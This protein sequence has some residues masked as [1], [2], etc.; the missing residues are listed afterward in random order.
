[1]RACAETE[2]RRRIQEA[3]NRQ[4]GIEPK[5]IQKAVG[6]LPQAK[7]PAAVTNLS[8]DDPQNFAAHVAKLE[9][10]MFAA[11][12]ELEFERAAELRDRIKELKTWHLQVG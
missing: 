3:Y 8:L 1:V 7:S 6:A 5:S 10:E 4:H 9:K 11:A 12:E 2:R